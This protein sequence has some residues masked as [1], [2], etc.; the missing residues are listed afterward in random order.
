MEKVEN[1]HKTQKKKRKNRQP[2]RAQSTNIQ[3]SN[4]NENDGKTE[5]KKQ[6]QQ[7]PANGDNLLCL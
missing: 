3:K 5:K 1:G 6:K 2:N 7:Q 4:R